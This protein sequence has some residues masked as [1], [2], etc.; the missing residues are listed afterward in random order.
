MMAVKALL[1]GVSHDQVAELYGVSRRTLSTWVN[2]FNSQGIDGLIEQRRSGR[3]VKI[4]PEKADR[5]RELIK[6]PDRANESHST[7][8][9]FHGYLT[10]ALDQEVGYSMWCAGCM[11]RALLLKFLDLA[12]RARP[13]EANTF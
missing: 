12:E 13:K 3:P 11:I 10:G 7:A 2:R 1:L 4:R 6:R 9:K 8:R 5:F